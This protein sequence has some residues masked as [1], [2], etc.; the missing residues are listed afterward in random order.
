[1]VN[2]IYSRYS[3]IQ[4]SCTHA[5]PYAYESISIYLLTDGCDPG[6]YNGRMWPETDLGSVASISCPCADIVGSLA[7]RIFRQCQGR[8][9]EGAD[10]L[11]E[12]DESQCAA[13]NSGITSK[14][15]AIAMVDQLLY[16]CSQN[17]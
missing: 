3:D 13:I 9:I 11:D 10:W 16:M 12:V 2:Y 15:C 6:I 1:M 4:C 17:Y 5:F 8:Y 14:L 7:G